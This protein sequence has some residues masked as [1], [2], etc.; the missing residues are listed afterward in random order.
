MNSWIIPNENF[1]NIY[2]YK[3]ELI[4]L[5]CYFLF[6][7]DVYKKLKWFSLGNVIKLTKFINKNNA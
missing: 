7:D 2:Q 5:L 1:L 6:I 3:L 4:L